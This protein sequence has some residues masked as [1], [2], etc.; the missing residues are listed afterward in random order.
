MTTSVADLARFAVLQRYRGGAAGGA[1]ILSGRTLAEMHR[2][3]W[4][5]PE[6][7]AGWGLG[8]RLLRVRD[9][10]LVGHGGAVRG[11]RGAISR[12]ARPTRSR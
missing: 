2:A 6:W 12:S 4:L 5:E 8:F 10:T 7:Q 3:H 9:R 11:F 1:Q